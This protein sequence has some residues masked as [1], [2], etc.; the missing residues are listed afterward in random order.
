MHHIKSL[1]DQ[2]GRLA[3][4]RDEREPWSYLGSFGDDFLSEDDDE[5]EVA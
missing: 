5:A 3:I 4:R 1:L 2:V